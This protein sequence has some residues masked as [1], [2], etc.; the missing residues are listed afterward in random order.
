M[1]Y[2]ADDDARAEALFLSHVQ[3]SDPVA[4]DALRSTIDEIMIRHGADMCA[5]L[6][7]YEYGEH[8][9]S[10]ARRMSWCRRIVDGIFRPAAL[11][12]V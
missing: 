6:V 5:E 8:P 10:A 11:R 1:R 7:A 3:A 4:L 2:P 9:D 12:S